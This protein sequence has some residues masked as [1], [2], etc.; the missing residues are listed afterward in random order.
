[1][2]SFLVR[3]VVFVIG[4]VIDGFCLAEVEAVEVTERVS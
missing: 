4:I 1:M 3:D 2:G